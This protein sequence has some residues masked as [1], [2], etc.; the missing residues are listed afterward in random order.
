MPDIE[1]RYMPAAELRA[2]APADDKPAVIEGYAAV[3]GALSADMGFR[4]EIAPG[5]FTQSLA[6]GD[7]VRALV[8]HDGGRILGR[9]KAGTLDLEEDA[10]G[11]H[12]TIRPPDTTAA[13]D[14]MASIDRGDVDGMSFGF[15]TRSDSW[16]M[17]EDG[18]AI[19]T[20]RD[21]KL[22]D[23]SVVTFPAYPDTTVAVRSLD[24]WKAEN[25]TKPPVLT[26][27]NEARLRL[28]ETD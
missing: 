26:L 15:Q 27:L 1:R 14:I 17:E 20:L 8:D 3:F 23:V 21:A 9:R 7:D 22:M 25:E 28:A 13:R 18:V 12:V 6:D 19:R 24:G 16:R 5:A 2:V 10:K 11:L 4:E